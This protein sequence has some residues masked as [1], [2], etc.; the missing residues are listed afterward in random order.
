M[1]VAYVILIL[2]VGSVFAGLAIHQELVSSSLPLENLK[3]KTYSLVNGS[4]ALYLNL[5]TTEISPGQAIHIIAM[6]YYRGNEPLIINSSYFSLPAPYPC[7]QSRPIGLNIFKGYYTEANISKAEPLILIAP[8]VYDCPNLFL[9]TQYK[10]LPSSDSMQLIYQGKVVDTIPNEFSLNVSGYWIPN[11]SST[12]II[13]QGS[14]TT[15]Q[16]GIYTVQLLDYFNQ[17]VLG[18]FTVT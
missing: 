2:V 13:P 9:A 15:F 7:A 14:F 11:N 12:S 17:S 10:L 6:M 1:K 18:Y 3:G 5:N 4:I 16:P 8:G